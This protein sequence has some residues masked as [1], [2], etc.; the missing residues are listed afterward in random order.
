MIH[1]PFALTSIGR[2]VFLLPF[3]RRPF[4]IAN[5]V[6]ASIR[7]LQPF[8]VDKKKPPSPGALSYGM[9]GHFVAPLPVGQGD[10]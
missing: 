10:A 8:H 1:S 2:L 9:A 3:Y 7:T 5:R 4:F 6:M